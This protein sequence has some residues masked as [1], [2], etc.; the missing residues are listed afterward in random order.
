MD[1]VLTKNLRQRDSSEFYEELPESN[2]VD[3]AIQIVDLCKSFG[4]NHVLNGV[5]LEIHDGEF[6]AVVGRS[7]CGKSTLLRLLAGLETP[8]SGKI[9]VRGK[10]LSGINRHVRVMFQDARLMPWMKVQDNVGLG[11]NGNWRPLAD[12]AL[13][14]V[15]LETRAKDWPGIL[16]GG[17]RQRVSLA[18]A[19][20]NQPQFML[21]DEPHGSLDAFTKFDMQNLLERMW[22]KR[23][24]AALLITHDVEEAI[25]LADRVILIQDGRIV[26]NVAVDLERPRNRAC[27]RFVELRRDVLHSVSGGILGPGAEI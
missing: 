18:R 21:L 2:I 23:R 5:N 4:D 22:L 25:A 17:Q 19:L 24:F 12:E 1:S 16:S 7:G 9:I 6:I 20:V 13:T 8:T 15:G 3:S 11:L 14:D 10:E 27:S 26:M